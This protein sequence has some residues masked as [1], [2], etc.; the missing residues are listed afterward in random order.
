MIQILG[1]KEDWNFVDSLYGC[2]LCGEETILCE[3]LSGRRLC[4]DHAHKHPISLENARKKLDKHDHV[5]VYYKPSVE[6]DAA[7]YRQFLADN[8]LTENLL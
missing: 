2:S 5:D 7:F 8:N 1:A 3:R 4:L 6:E